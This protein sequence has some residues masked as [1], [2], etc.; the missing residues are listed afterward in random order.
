MDQRIGFDVLQ[1]DDERTLRLVGDLDLLSHGRA[2]EAIEQRTSERGDL[3]LDLS[4]LTFIDSSGVRVLVQAL[5]R[6]RE[7]GERLVLVAPPAHV[8]R[9]FDLLG[10]ASIGL[11]VQEQ[12]AE[13][14]A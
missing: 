12:P 11:V 9:V 4:G 3:R 14:R 10:L 2:A 6:L 1:T 5:K 7:R 8:K 13:P